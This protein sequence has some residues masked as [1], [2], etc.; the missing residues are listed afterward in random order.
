MFQFLWITYKKLYCERRHILLPLAWMYFR[1]SNLRFLCVRVFAL[2]SRY[3]EQESASTFIMRS[4]RVPVIHY[5]PPNIWS[6]CTCHEIRGVTAHLAIKLLSKIIKL[7]VWIGIWIKKNLYIIHCLES[8][9]WQARQLV[10]RVVLLLLLLLKQLLPYQKFCP[11]L[12]R[13]F[14]LQSWYI[15]TPSHPLQPLHE[16]E[17]FLISDF[18]TC[19]HWVVK[20]V[21]EKLD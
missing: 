6:W 13:P 16:N 8:P 1:C 19:C 4:A 14:A 5:S 18:S 9:H 7:S 20:N 12:V 11:S 10:V 3:L 21:C 2:S 17:N 15:Y